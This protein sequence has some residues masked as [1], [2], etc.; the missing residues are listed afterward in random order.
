MTL[1]PLIYQDPHLTVTN[2]VSLKDVVNQD[3][4]YTAIERHKYKQ[5][6][7]LEGLP[8]ELNLISTPSGSQ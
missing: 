7:I 1:M 8:R 2:A 5:A 3:L 6:D 4:D